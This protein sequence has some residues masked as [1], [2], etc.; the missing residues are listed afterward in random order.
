[1]KKLSLFLFFTVL[2]ISCENDNGVRPEKVKEEI[3]ADLKGKVF[4][5]YSAY[6]L[7]NEEGNRT[8]L[9]PSE[10]YFTNMEFIGNVVELTF[11]NNIKQ[12]FGFDVN[13]ANR[14]SA[15]LPDLYTMPVK[16][17]YKGFY[18]FLELDYSNALVTITD[19]KY[20]YGVNLKQ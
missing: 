11:N 19:G 18:I 10:A 4:T 7:N 9:D 6:V 5:A 13:N 16:S 2:F 12:R 1:M 20:S 15:E 14:G 3:V 17:E 8:E